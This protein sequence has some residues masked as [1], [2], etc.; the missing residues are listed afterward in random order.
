MM[1]P[2]KIEFPPLPGTEDEQWEELANEFGIS[3]DEIKQAVFPSWMFDKGMIN[4][5]DVRKIL[6]GKGYTQ[7]IKPEEDDPEKAYNEWLEKHP[8][9]KKWYETCPQLW[10]GDPGFEKPKKAETINAAEKIDLDK[11]DT[12]KPTKKE[13]KINSKDGRAGAYYS[14]GE[15]R[16]EELMDKKPDISPKDDGAYANGLK[17]INDIYDDQPDSN[18]KSNNVMKEYEKEIK[19]E[20]QCDP[21]DI[22]IAEN[23][24]NLEREAVEKRMKEREQRILKAYAEDKKREEIKQEMKRVLLSEKEEQ[25]IKDILHINDVKK[26]EEYIA[27]E[28]KIV[29]EPRVA[30][31]SFDQIC[32]EIMELH[33]KK[34]NDY[35]NAADASYRE[36]GLI[37]YIIRL[38]DKLNR[39]KTLTKPGTDMAVNDESIIDTFKDLAAYSIMAVESLLND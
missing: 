1:P 18:V 38:N 4:K 23:N 30:N 20:K 9:A 36:F 3:L 35:G 15:D 21:R 10:P 33:R 27:P 19:M 12:P 39:L 11:M 25:E 17:D 7:K 37:S 28:C 34:N 2:R 14:D 5:W 8:F 13:I 22:Y 32:Y 31:G 24:R 6:I 16:F 26:K 29:D